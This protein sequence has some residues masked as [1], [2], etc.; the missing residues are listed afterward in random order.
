[1]CVAVVQMALYF[2]RKIRGKHTY[3]AMRWP[4][5]SLLNVLLLLIILRLSYHNNQALLLLSCIVPLYVIQF[6]VDAV[7]VMESYDEDTSLKSMS[8]IGGTAKTSDG[9]NELMQLQHVPTSAVVQSTVSANAS[10]SVSLPIGERY[11]LW[12]CVGS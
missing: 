4:T 5:R 7:R 11:V 2:R 12:S 9:N 6:C 8:S 10:A 3:G 1:M